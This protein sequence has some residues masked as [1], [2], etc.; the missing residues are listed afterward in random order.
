MKRPRKRILLTGC[1]LTIVGAISV[2]A[3]TVAMMVGDDDGVPRATIQGEDGQVIS[4]LHAGPTDAPRIIYVHGS[5]GNARAWLDYLKDPI[6]GF[7][8]I[9][10]DRPGFGQTTP[11][12]PVPSLEE[13]AKAIE[14]F[15]VKRNG[16]WPILVGHSLGATIVCRAAADF[17]DR[18]GGLVVIS[19]ALDPDLEKTHWY[20]TLGE[21]GFVPSI[22]PRGLR[23]SNRELLP[24]KAELQKLEPLLAKITCP[25]I[26][27]HGKKDALVPVSNVTYLEEHL[28][29][30]RVRDEVLFK[31]RNHLI[32]WSEDGAIRDAIKQAAAEEKGSDG[33]G[34]SG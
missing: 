30:G 10:L 14:P 24:L 26:V 5:P 28:T 15:L 27:L 29:K 3:L 6:P 9:A 20:Q 16:K 2:V 4:Y 32:P 17:A 19:G 11:H 34:R 12:T 7:E 23:N 1:L 33:S 18:V 13:Q 25:V 22:L 31:D 8:S 21:V